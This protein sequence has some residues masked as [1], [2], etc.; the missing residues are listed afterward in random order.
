[1]TY[2]V[3]KVP[4]NPNQPTNSKQVVEC[5]D[6]VIRITYFTVA[7]AD[8]N[9]TGIIFICTGHFHHNVAS[10]ICVNLSRK[11]V[12]YCGTSLSYFHFYAAKE[13][14]VNKL[15]QYVKKCIA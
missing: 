11:S 15:L 2:S 5:G 3:L 9:D 13:M 1:M 8:Q 10:E 4:L 6:S 7:S 14:A 12:K